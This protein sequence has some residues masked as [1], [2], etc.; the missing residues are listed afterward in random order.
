MKKLLS[1]LLAMAL[2]ASCVPF[3]SAENAGRIYSRQYPIYA[4]DEE[5]KFTNEYPLF[6]IDGVDDMPWIDVEE[7][8]DIATILQREVIES[9]SFE[10]TYKQEGSTITLTR[11]N[12]FFMHLDFDKNVITFSDYNAFVKKPEAQTLLDLLNVS[13][14]NEAGEA[15][16]FQRDA[17]ASYDRYGDAMVLDLSEY[18]IHLVMDEDRGYIPL[19]TANDFV[20]SPLMDRSLLF[21][22]AAM[23]FANDSDLYDINTGKYTPLAELYYSVAPQDRSAAFADYGYNELCLMLDSLYGLKKKHNID[24]FAH[25]F[26]EIGFD[27]LLSDTS[28]FNADQALYN[29]ICYYLDDL[30]SAFGLRSWMTGRERGLEGGDGPSERSFSAQEKRYK[31][32]REK[33][34]GEKV[35]AYQEVGDTAYV[36]FDEFTSKYKGAY[37]YEAAAKGT[38]LEDTI[39]LMIYAHQQIN[40]E[41]SPIKNVVIDL[42]NNIGGSA[43]AALFVISWILGEAEVSIEDTFTSAQTTMVYRADVNLDHK[44]DERDTLDGKH[45]YC[46]ISPVSFS[47]GNLVPAVC[48]ENQAVTLIGR[49]SGGGAC[50]VQPMSTAWGAV[51]QI[52]GT[53]RL[54]FR[55][56]GSFYDI[57]EGVAPDVYLSRL[58]TMYDRAKLNDLINNLP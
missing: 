46:L 44:F 23:F 39:G 13:A 20:F 36:T 54:S 19:Q 37:Y 57:D 31:N 27:E 11:E 51:F 6:F 18:G 41:N 47:C 35:E 30:H 14:V 28:A 25:L 26:W 55:K 2:L 43:D 42:S 12:G 3:A 48:K 4:Y 49:T 24:T 15:E 17:M 10:L 22:T 38:R 50:V 40:R 5:T 9:S 34:L 45:V 8:A 33:F 56:N 58:E 32:M 53:S 1:L 21:N 29:F 52:S 7:M 16:L